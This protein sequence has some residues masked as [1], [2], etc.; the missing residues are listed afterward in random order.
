MREGA[1][2][3]LGEEREQQ[4]EE[5]AGEGTCWYLRPHGSEVA[6]SNTCGQV[7]AVLKKHYPRLINVFNYYCCLGSADAFSVQF[8]AYSEFLDDA[9]IP[10][11]ESKFCSENDLSTLFIAAN[12][13]EDGGT[14]ENK[15]NYQRALMRFEWLEVIV[16]IGFA[17][18]LK[19]KLVQ[20]SWESVE[21]LITENMPLVDAGALLDPND[22]RK[23]CLY[24]EDVDALLAANLKWLR[25][26]FN[27]YNQTKVASSKLKGM[28]SLAAWMEMLTRLGMF[29]EVR[30]AAHRRHGVGLTIP[31]TQTFNIREARLCFLWSR[32]VVIDDLLNREVYSSLNFIGEYAWLPDCL[33]ESRHRH[34]E[35]SQTF[36]KLWFELRTWL[37]CR[38]TSS[39]P[40]WVCQTRTTSLRV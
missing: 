16:R 6:D 1:L 10:D 12:V 26:M 23:R 30:T 35:P 15:I 3:A 40:K 14:E 25:K 39:L 17:K 7:K 18:Y 24:T 34:C 11:P 28:I 4:G 32:M 8:N 22:F 5:G 13:E 37:A 27:S 31:L 38:R 2:Q 9:H 33:V 20:H 19:S 36:W 21:L 29:S